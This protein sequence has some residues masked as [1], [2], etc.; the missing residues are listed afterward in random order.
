M[1]EPGLFDGKINTVYVYTFMAQFE[2][3]KMHTSSGNF[4]VA[5]VCN[6]LLLDLVSGPD[7][8]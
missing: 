6:L 1:P 5:L 2:V 3:H 8:S 4:A 7:P